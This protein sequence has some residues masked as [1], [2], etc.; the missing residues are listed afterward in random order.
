MFWVLCAL[1]VVAFYVGA[2]YRASRAAGRVGVVTR[3]AIGAA[4]LLLSWLVVGVMWAVMRVVL[5]AA[6]FDPAVI[7]VLNF[8][9]ALFLVIPLSYAYERVYRSQRPV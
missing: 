3:G 1:L 2:I 8:V 7:L 9:T 6:G 4:L 5:T